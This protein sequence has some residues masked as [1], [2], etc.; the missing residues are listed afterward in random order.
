MGV[1][2]AW[3]QRDE[4]EGGRTAGV[5]TFALIGLLGGLAGALSDLAGSYVPWLATLA[6]LTAIFA[7]F[8]FRQGVAEK[9]FSVTS[10]VVCMVVFGL[11][12]LALLGDLR[13]AAAAGVVTA[14]ILASRESLHRAVERLTWPE[15]RSAL[16]LAAMTAVILPVLPDQP[17]DPLGAINP[18]DIWLFMILT[19]A[20][21][22]AGY[23]ALKIGGPEKGPP[24]AGLAGGLA[25]STATTL[26]M[27]RLSRKVDD[28]LGLA[29]GVSFASMVSVVR[30]TFLAAVVAPTLLARLAPAA[31]A[32][33]LVFAAGGLL[34]LVRR[35][36]GV[37]SDSE[38]DVPF[39]LTAVFGF[40]VL[41][42]G[43]MLLSAWLSQSAGAA[44]VYVLA[45]VS[46]TVDVDAITLSQAREAAEGG[47]AVVAAAAILIALAS[48]AVQ[49]VIMAWTIG[50]R[51]FA[52]RFALVTGGALAAGAA[53]LAATLTL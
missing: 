47:P 53:A 5:R 49:R 25:S 13:I 12:V 46:G 24:L 37:S 44:G 28:S 9:D 3:R 19:A 21:S 31:G 26:A 10:V 1:E 4:R 14:S 33:A 48:N 2:R 8:S 7:V 20:V 29:A 27:A 42:A 40:G 35:T 16:L 39:E 18:R 34:A 15:L 43:I 32:A 17:V 51:P 41:L 52:V 45:A 11:G 22:Y 6:I 38:L 30:A 36:R 50:A 23:I